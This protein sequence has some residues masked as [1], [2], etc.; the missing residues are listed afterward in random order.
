MNKNSII[1]LLGLLGIGA[2]LTRRQWIA[3]GLW[4]SPSK[5]AVA[6]ERG[7]AVPM[8]DGIRLIADHYFPKAD[9]M[10]PTIL[11]RTPYGRNEAGGVLGV[12]YVFFAQR[13]A[14]RGYHVI[15]QDARGRFESEGA[16]E[17]F[18]DERRD[19][20]DTLNWIAR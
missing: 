10:F 11:M 5:Y 18:V 13:F 14:E 7:V 17:P 4:L 19:G 1:A 16:W 3:R 20:L 8:P 2:Y 6:V 15:V 12:L 9:G